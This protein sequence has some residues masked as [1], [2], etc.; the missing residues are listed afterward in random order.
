MYLEILLLAIPAL[1]LFGLCKST[2]NVATIRQSQRTTRKLS[3][4]YF[5]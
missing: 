5:E 4:T 2:E 1:I 3:N